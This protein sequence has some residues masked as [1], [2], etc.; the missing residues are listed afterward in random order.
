[1]STFADGFDSEYTLDHRYTRSEGRVF[2]TGTQA[3]V[4]IPL[5]QRQRDLA[6]G[7][8]TE[9]FIS[10]YRGSPLGTYDLALWQARRHL[11]EHRVHFEPGVNEDLAATAV[12]GSQLAADFSGARTDGVFGIWYGKGPGSCEAIP[13]RGVCEAGGAAGDGR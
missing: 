4:R 1:M 6:A 5:V 9:G 3:L 8:N 7:L 11:E 2:L 13:L 10:G 12:W